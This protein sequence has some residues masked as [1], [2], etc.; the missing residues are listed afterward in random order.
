MR[1][2]LQRRL[3]ALARKV[4]TGEAAVRFVFREDGDTDEDVE[5]KKRDLIASGAATP[6]DRIITCCWA[7]KEREAAGN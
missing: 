6:Y 3:D 1:R 2:S 4:F 5:A 7:P